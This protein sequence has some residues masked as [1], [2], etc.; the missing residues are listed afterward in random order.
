LEVR[1]FTVRGETALDR[2]VS[3]AP[4]SPNSGIEFS[5]IH[6]DFNRAPGRLTIN[7]GVVKG[8]A[9]GGEIDGGTIDYVQ[10]NMNLRGTIVPAYGLNNLPN[11]IIAGIPGVGDVVGGLIGGKNSGVIA[12]TFDVVGP[13]SLPEFRL[14]PLSALAPGLIKKIFDFPMMLQSPTNNSFADPS[15]R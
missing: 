1:D 14:Y 4:G 3:G 7:G 11:T 12:F 13:P 9:I 2:V 6:V 15:R 10:N 5:L 8:A